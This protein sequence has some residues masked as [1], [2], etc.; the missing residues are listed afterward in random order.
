MR[1]SSFFHRVLSFLFLILLLPGCDAIRF[2]ESDS[3]VRE[4]VSVSEKQVLSVRNRATGI[5]SSL[6]KLQ[7]RDMEPFRI[8]DTLLTVSIYSD[9]GRIRLIDERVDAKETGNARNRYYFDDESMFH[10][11]GK[12]SQRVNPGEAEAQFAKVATRLY[13]NDAGN[14]FDYEHKINGI[15]SDLAENEL[16][17]VMQRSVALRM[18]TNTDSFGAIDTAA[19]V[20]MLYRGGNST[21]DDIPP[22]A[23]DE[24]TEIVQAETAPEEVEPVEESPAQPQTKKAAP[25]PSKAETK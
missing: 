5:Q 18:L 9:N 3:G 22:P 2:W 25:P 12:S 17:S 7:R 1:R 24:N 4:T 13:F 16:P 11:F 10:F 8:G 19:F 15:V 14:L 20:A 21:S 23:M 6:E